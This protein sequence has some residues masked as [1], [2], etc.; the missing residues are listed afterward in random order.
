MGSSFDQ[1]VINYSMC[2]LWESSRGWDSR[3]KRR[4]WAVFGRFDAAVL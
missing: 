2:I 1:T 3:R 4:K